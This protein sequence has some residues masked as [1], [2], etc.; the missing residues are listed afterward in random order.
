M[1]TVRKLCK[2]FAS[3]DSLS[4]REEL[5]EKIESIVRVYLNILYKN[6]IKYKTR[7]MFDMT[8]FRDDR[9]SLTYDYAT[10]LGIYVKYTDSWSYG[11]HCDETFF[12]TFEDLES[13]DE[14]ILEM[15]S[16]EDAR[17]RLERDIRIA[18]AVVEKAKLELVKLN[19]ENIR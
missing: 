4:E 6:S 3:S 12:I 9:G 16:I 10:N 13:F 18:E 19:N 2:Q 15:K 17:S 5:Q 8:D 1:K 11:G 14:E 7:S